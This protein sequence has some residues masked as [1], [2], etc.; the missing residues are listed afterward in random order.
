MYISSNIA[1]MNSHRN[2]KL[3]NDQRAKTMEKLSSGY[4]INRGADDAAG[5]AISENMRFQINGLTQASRNIQD[6]ISLIQTA[7]GGMKEIQ[8]MLQRMNTLANQASNG[9]YSNEDRTKLD[10]EFQQLKREIN[11]ITEGTIFNEIKLLNGETS[12]DK[13][14][15]KSSFRVTGGG[16][17]DYTTADEWVYVGNM[18]AKVKLN[19][20]EQVVEDSSQ[21]MFT[22]LKLYADIDSVGAYGLNIHTDT[23]LVVVLQ[24]P[25]TSFTYNG[26]TFDVS[27]VGNFSGGSGGNSPMGT[28]ILNVGNN[29]SEINGKGITIQTGVNADDTLIL[30]MPNVN[31][32]TIGIFNLNISTISGASN[33][34]A[35]LESAINK[36]SS[37]RA[38]MGAYQNRLEHTLNNVRNYAVNLSAA[39]SRIRDADMA[40]EMTMLT[41][42]Q[43]IAEAGQS[44]LA[45][46]NALPQNILKLLG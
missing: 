36:V 5:L 10:L 2:I 37:E 21:W 30:D 38:K 39:Q 18:G 14:Q 40:A 42:S 24:H 41:K 43:I 34:I 32:S 15:G 7:E 26:M 27:E 29:D 19:S 22:S 25:S 11:N 44:M 31:S 8:A 17:T 35:S 46:A 1:A 33:A 3:I 16:G 9:T 13:I 23:G 28:I 45:Q 4:R 20:G 6:G 12:T